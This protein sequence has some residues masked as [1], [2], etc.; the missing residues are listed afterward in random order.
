LSAKWRRSRKRFR[1]LNFIETFK[2]KDVAPSFRVFKNE[3]VPLKRWKIPYKYHASRTSGK[4]RLRDP[5]PLIDVI[6]EKDD[7]VVIAEFAGFNRENLNVRVDN[8]RL[9]L[10]AE[11][12][13]RKYYKSLNLP[14]KVI[15]STMRLVHRNGVLEIRVKKIVEEKPIDKVAS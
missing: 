10:S 5:E 13:G 8:Q 2:K 14:S 15:S 1:K 6:D 9:T 7:V 3:N 12:S 11:A 4:T